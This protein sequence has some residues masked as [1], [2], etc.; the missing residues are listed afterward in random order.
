MQD[1]V[2]SIMNKTVEI[3]KYTARGGTQ[4]KEY[5][6]D[7]DILVKKLAIFCKIAKIKLVILKNDC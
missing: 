4:L 7:L 5:I 3:L 2:S 1:L 6:D